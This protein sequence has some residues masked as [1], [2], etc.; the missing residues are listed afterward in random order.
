MWNESS[1]N[2]F[3]S[4]CAFSS[5]RDYLHTLLQDPL[6]RLLWS[7]WASRKITS[8]PCSF[9]NSLCICSNLSS[10]YSIQT[11]PK[12]RP[13]YDRHVVWLL[14]FNLGSSRY[15]WSLFMDKPSM[16]PWMCRCYQSSLQRNL[17]V[18]RHVH[19]RLVGLLLLIRVYHR[20]SDICF[21]L[22]YCAR[23]NILVQFW[24]SKWNCT[25]QCSFCAD[26]W[27]FEAA[28]SFL[29]IR[30]HNSLALDTVLQ[31]SPK[32]SVERWWKSVLRRWWWL[33]TDIKMIFNVINY[34]KFYKFNN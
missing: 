4:N 20:D 29:C 17:L 18:L 6:L 22:S 1:K 33:K 26:E 3:G 32:R 19:R 28:T 11:L 30:L 24:L 7:F 34:V 10:R 27:T 16:Q 12:T 21:K 25:D 5:F 8:C 31:I 23:N 14:R 15:K 9:R 13:H 2:V